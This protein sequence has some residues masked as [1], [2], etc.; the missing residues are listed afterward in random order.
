MMRPVES[1]LPSSEELLASTAVLSLVVSL[2]MS[3]NI[4]EDDVVSV[5]DSESV[6]SSDELSEEEDSEADEVDSTAVDVSVAEE[7]DASEELSTP[8]E[9][10]EGF[11]TL[12]SSAGCVA[13]LA[14]P[15]ARPSAP[16]VRRRELEVVEV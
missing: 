7:E 6:V 1:L 11:E 15:P 8:A 3:L 9:S 2:L 5:A 16:S 12:S 14:F 13:S 4:S 10:L